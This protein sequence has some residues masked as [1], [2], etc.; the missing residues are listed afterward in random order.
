MSAVIHGQSHKALKHLRKPTPTLTVYWLYCSRMNNEGV[1]WTSLRRLA[2]DTGWSINSPM[3]ARRY[4]VKHKALEPVK[5]Y[6][7]PAWRKLPE[8]E[9]KRK[10]QLD[11]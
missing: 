8:A 4:L 5:N 6:V 9:R 2:D 3:P 11:H 1:A 7:R 10:M